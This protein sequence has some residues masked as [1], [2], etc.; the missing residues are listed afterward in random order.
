[1]RKP[2]TN[3]RLRFKE[4]LEKATEAF[5]PVPV[6]AIPSNME[7]AANN[8]VEKALCGLPLLLVMAPAEHDQHS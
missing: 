5:I 4:E 2:L 6:L 7:G 3:T 1:M 8:L